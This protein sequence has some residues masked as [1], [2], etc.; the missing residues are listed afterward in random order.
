MDVLA[1]AKQAEIG[2]RVTYAERTQDDIEGRLYSYTLS[3]AMRAHE[4]GLVFL[5][6]RRTTLGWAYEATRISLPVARKLRL[7]PVPPGYYLR[8]KSFA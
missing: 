8:T 1:W 4:E 3:S 2:E 7:V 5:A 6:Q